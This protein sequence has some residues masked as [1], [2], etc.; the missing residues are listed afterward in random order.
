MPLEYYLGGA[1][2]LI[3][4]VL[5]GMALTGKKSAR[6]VV[7]AKNADDEDL[8]RQ[9]ARAADALEALLAHLRAHPLQVPTSV[10][11][12]PDR[13]VAST[14]AADMP[15][16]A[17]PAVAARRAPEPQVAPTPVSP[18]DVPPEQ[19]APEPGLVEPTAAPEA[20]AAGASAGQKPRRVKL[21]MFGR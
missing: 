7:V 14:R 5:L 1:V 9:V 11:P 10:Q 20:G 16:Q 12:V 15:V 4:L 18:G 3:V 2:A 21:S 8:A 6:R 17:P 13:P 19:L